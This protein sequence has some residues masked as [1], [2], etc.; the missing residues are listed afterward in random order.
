MKNKRNLK[1]YFRQETFSEPDGFIGDSTKHLKK[2]RYLFF[3]NYFKKLKRME[4]FQAYSTNP[5]LPDTKTR[6]IHYKKRKLQANID[7]HKM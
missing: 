3:L 2:K 1:Q 4:C 5:A 7:E 6:Q